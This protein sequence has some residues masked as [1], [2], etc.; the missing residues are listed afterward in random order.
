M[1]DPRNCDSFTFAKKPSKFFIASTLIGLFLAKGSLPSFW[2]NIRVAV[3]IYPGICRISRSLQILNFSKYRLCRTHSSS[4]RI[5]KIISIILSLYFLIVASPAFLG[6]MSGSFTPAFPKDYEKLTSL[7]ETDSGFGRLLWLPAKP[8]LG[9]ISDKKFG[10][11][12]CPF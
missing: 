9:P 12:R 2:A 11:N 4:S 7:L 5:K 1:V 8:P 3:Q 6:K 10:Q